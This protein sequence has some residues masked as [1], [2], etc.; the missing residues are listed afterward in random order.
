LAVWPFKRRQEFP[1]EADADD[2][3]DA[4]EGAANDLD[5]RQVAWEEFDK[6]FNPV[7]PRGGWIPPEQALPA[8]SPA[9]P[10]QEDQV[11]STLANDLPPSEW[12]P[13]RQPTWR[14]ELRWLWR[15]L[16]NWFKTPPTAGEFVSGAATLVE[17]LRLTLMHGQHDAR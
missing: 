9:P 12:E 1:Q 16:R 8:R 2:D 14:Q 13:G 15:D 4:R 5:A 7:D 3:P 17:D 6:N 10:Q 11:Q